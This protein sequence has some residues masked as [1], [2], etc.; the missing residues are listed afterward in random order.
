MLPDIVINLKEFFLRLTESTIRDLRQSEGT[1][2]AGRMKPTEELPMTATTIWKLANNAVEKLSETLGK[3]KNNRYRL[4]KESFMEIRDTLPSVLFFL[5]KIESQWIMGAESEKAAKGLVQA[6]RIG[7]E[8]VGLLNT[9]WMNEP[10]ANMLVGAAILNKYLH[11]FKNASAAPFLNHML[12]SQDKQMVELRKLYK[13]EEIINICKTE[14]RLLNG[15]ASYNVGEGNWGDYKNWS[16]KQDQVALELAATRY[17]SKFLIARKK[18]P[19]PIEI[20]KR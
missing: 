15:L 3:R 19:V 5:T 9:K 20:S 12:K 8:D 2:G 7:A 13:K 18:V 16:N 17:V 11:R 4:Q 6:R 1:L 14:K 10:S